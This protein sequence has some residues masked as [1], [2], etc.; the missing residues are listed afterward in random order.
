[1]RRSTEEV[2]P[3]RWQ[4][5]R[6]S[7]LNAR[8]VRSWTT[9]A[10]DGIIATSGVLEGFSGAGATYSMLVTAATAT[11]VA[12]AVG[13][14]SAVWAAEA[15]EREAQ[16]ELESDER[17]E[18]ASDP[19]GALAALAAHYEEKGLTPAL[20]REV[21]EQL[22]AVDALGAQLE[23]EHGID[24]VMSRATPLWAGVSSALAFA[25]GASVPLLITL[26]VSPAVESWAIL[27]AAI[28]SLALTSLVTARAGDIS[29]ART[30]TRTLFVGI[31]TL[32][33][34]YL[35]GRAFL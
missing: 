23:A 28:V 24:E 13:L 27:V 6:R 12:G 18:L 19:A 32:A 9:G 29:V 5:L 33:I 31:G 10:N 22:T 3:T 26:S 2:L 30:L 7:I 14:G 21:A 34:S 17:S 4:R 1:M 20:A 8:A 35:V 15:A 16:L 25:L 11:T